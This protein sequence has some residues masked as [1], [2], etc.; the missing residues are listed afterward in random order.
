[1]CSVWLATALVC[2]G[3]PVRI[4]RPSLAREV[5]QVLSFGA[6]VMTGRLGW[7]LYSNADMVIVGRLLGPT[8]LG[9]Y[10]LAW[11]LASIPL[12][13]VAGAITEV[14]FPVLSSVKD[15]DAELGRY[16]SGLIEVLALFMLPV[17]IGMALVST[18][19]FEGILGSKWSASA[20]PFAILAMASSSR[21]FSAVVQQFLLAKGDARFPAR[22]TVLATVIMPAIIYVVAPHGI[23][24]V[25][26][27]WL[28]VHPAL[29]L[30]PLLLRAGR[31]TNTSLAALAAPALPAVLAVAFMAAIVLT[32]SNLLP[33]PRSLESLAVLS[34]AGATSYG[35]WLALVHRRRLAQLAGLISQVRAAR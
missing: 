3:K 6:N 27:T 31:A 2:M 9:F 26:M 1:M 13:R 28:I 17:T 5:R 18:D 15:D 33:L 24:A 11:Q 25:A 12:T 32:A 16:F 23:A 14:L 30:V 4:R 35:G 10:A 19:L 7:Y 29:V 8:Q 21:L 20:V 34:A 22:L